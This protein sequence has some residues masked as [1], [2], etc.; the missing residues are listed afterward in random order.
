MLVVKRTPNRVYYQIGLRRKMATAHVLLCID[1]SVKGRFVVVDMWNAVGRHG[2][3]PETYNRPIAASFV[4]CV[5]RILD[6]FSHDRRRSQIAEGGDAS[7]SESR[8]VAW[9]EL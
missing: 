2:V 1:G 8:T 4:S 9:A 6:E 7:R 5:V 3:Q